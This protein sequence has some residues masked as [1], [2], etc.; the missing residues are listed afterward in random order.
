MTTNRN[1][2]VKRKRKEDMQLIKFSI[3]DTT[4]QF[5]K[6]KFNVADVQAKELAQELTTGVLQEIL[7]RLTERA[8]YTL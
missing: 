4:E 3:K 5:L 8:E 7:K 2:E 6:E 1:K